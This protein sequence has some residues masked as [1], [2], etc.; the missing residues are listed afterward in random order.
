MLTYPTT[1]GFFLLAASRRRVSSSRESVPLRASSAEAILPL[2]QSPVL[3]ATPM[4]FH[5]PVMARLYQYV[6]TSFARDQPIDRRRL[7]HV[8]H[9][10]VRAEHAERLVGRPVGDLGR[11]RI[12]LAVDHSW[13]RLDRDRL[14][15][16]VERTAG[17]VGVEARGRRRVVAALCRPGDGGCPVGRC[18][19]TQRPWRPRSRFS[20]RRLR[21]P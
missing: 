16:G 15:V 12:R 17:G 4:F 7:T 14:A 9:V 6:S 3:G 1:S 11:G 21:S 19:R 20:V 10:L 5:P 18:R 8:R 13:L 2:R